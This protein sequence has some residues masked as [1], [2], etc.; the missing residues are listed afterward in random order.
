MK[1]KQSNQSLFA[2]I[3]WGPKTHGS[4]VGATCGKSTRAYERGDQFEKRIQ[5]MVDWANFANT[6]NAPVQKVVALRRSV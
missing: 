2:G 4:K 3:V 5:L 6:I 1:S